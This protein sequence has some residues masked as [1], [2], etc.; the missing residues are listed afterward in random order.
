MKEHYSL[1]VKSAKVMAVGEAWGK[2]EAAAGFALA[3]PTGAVFD[4]LVGAV[5]LPRKVWSITNVFNE[6]PPED[7]VVLLKKDPEKLAAARKRLLEEIHITEPN[8]IVAM[9]NTALQQLTGHSGIGNLRGH[10]LLASNMALYGAKRP[11]KVLPIIHPVQVYRDPTAR[12]KILMDLFKA[13]REAEYPELRYTEREIW[14]EP[15]IDDLFEFQQNFITSA[16]YLSVDIE[17]VSTPVRQITCIGF[18]PDPH[19]SI[20][21][22][23]VDQQKPGFS[24]WLEH[25]EF[26]AH[27]WCQ[28]M[29]D[30]PIPKI[31]QNGTYDLHWLA[32]WGF[33]PRGPFEDTMILHHAKYSE[34][35]KGLEALAAIYSN[36]PPWKTLRPR[37]TDE[38]REG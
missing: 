32:H 20:V 13:A 24:Y 5:G 15:G 7:A 25:E 30:L 37:G 34:L 29:L 21:V 9:G 11:Y 1:L 28:R 26:I 19:H 23:F 14:I 8:L 2:H 38:K 10:C 17:T 33:R 6:R 3:G 16:K 18:S 12:A 31:L 36:S 27:A 22:P 4:E 35:P